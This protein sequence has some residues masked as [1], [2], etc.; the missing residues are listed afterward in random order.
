[1]SSINAD[2]MPG[3]ASASTERSKARRFLLAIPTFWLALTFGVLGL[4]VDAVGPFR[5]AFAALPLAL[6]IASLL[7]QRSRPQGE[8]A[9]TRRNLRRIA[10]LAEVPELGTVIMFYGCMIVGL[11]ITTLSLVALYRSPH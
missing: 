8:K 7:L 10:R 5:L 11:S 3:G 1:M 2:E 6:I 4:W 9:I